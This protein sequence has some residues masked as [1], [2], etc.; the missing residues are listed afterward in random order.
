MLLGRKRGGRG[1]FFRLPLFLPPTVNNKPLLLT[2]Q[3]RSRVVGSPLLFLLLNHRRNIWE[4]P[5]VRSRYGEERGGTSRPL[6]RLASIGLWPRAGGGGREKRGSWRP[7][8]PSVVGVS[9]LSSTVVAFSSI[10][11]PIYNNAVE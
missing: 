3:I 5:A 6:I 11:C 2:P 9:P 7:P 1:T 10:P 8:P 4:L